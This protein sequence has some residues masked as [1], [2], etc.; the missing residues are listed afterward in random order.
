MRCIVVVVASAWNH[1]SSRVTSDG[2]HAPGRRSPRCSKA[3]STGRLCWYLYLCVCVCGFVCVGWSVDGSR[4]VQC[5][6]PFGRSS[7]ALRQS[8]TPSHPTRTNITKHSTTTYST[9]CC[10]WLLRRGCRRRCDRLTPPAA[11]TPA[12]GS[13]ACAGGPSRSDDASQLPSQAP[14]YCPLSLGTQQPP[15]QAPAAVVLGD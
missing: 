9:Q 6:P 15:P 10:T 13:C 7:S 1:R 14:P 2:G 11:H 12:S 5:I 3:R 8:N 4:K